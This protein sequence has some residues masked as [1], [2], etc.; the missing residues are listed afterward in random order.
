MA[1]AAWIVA[2][3]S[4]A[5]Y[6]LGLAAI[7]WCA[8]AVIIPLERMLPY[9]P[10]WNR[11]QGDFAVDLFHMVFSFSLTAKAVE[12]AVWAAF[13]G[14]AAWL[15]EVAGFGLWPSHWSLP[16]QLLLSVGLAEAGLYAI[17]RLAHEN[18][19][20]WRL[21]AVHHS[22]PRLYW[23]NAGR[24]HPLD[25]AVQSL[26]GMLPL[27]LLG[28]PAPVLFLHWTFTGVH[29]LLQHSNVAMRLGFLSHIFSTAELHRW[30]HS[31]DLREADNNYGKVLALFDTLCG[32]RYRPEGEVGELGLGKPGFPKGILGHLASPFR[33][34][35]F[36]EADDSH[37][38]LNGRPRSRISP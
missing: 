8:I 29:G 4:P 16:L 3:A 27:V 34:E 7:L 31:R 20:L 25:V 15:G 2:A 36:I 22:A 33:W 5:S 30:H 32:T 26:P 18:A 13:M 37:L 28:A 35:G 11:N 12:A 38:S 24:F 14:A 23:L 1:A 21:H 19:W 9:R 6:P 10:E 17:H